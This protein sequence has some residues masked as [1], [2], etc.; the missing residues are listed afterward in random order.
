M[1][2][3]SKSV[4][5]K[6]PSWKVPHS[7]PAFA[8]GPSRSTLSAFSLPS[9][10]VR[11]SRASI[12][13]RIARVVEV[14]QAAAGGDYSQRL[15]V[16]STDELGVMSNALNT[17]TAAV[18]KAMQRRRDAA[19]REQK[20]QQDRAEAERRQTE[21]QREREAEEARRSNFASRKTTAPA[22]P[23]RKGTAA[24]RT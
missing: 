20:A 15:D 7:T 10:W 4:P 3:H 22:G 17:T 13:R 21:Q 24:G 9:R 6:K 14:L 2:I 23:S 16:D 12:S 8:T 5:T 1:V 19:E 11:S 18:A